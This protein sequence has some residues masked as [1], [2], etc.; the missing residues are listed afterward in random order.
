MKK[1][2]LID[3][4]K[5][6][7]LCFCLP[8]IIGFL[9]FFIKPVSLSIRYAFSSLNFTPD[10]LVISFVGLKNFK[11]ALFVDPTYI[12]TIVTSARDMVIRVPIVLL[13]SLFIAVVLSHKFKG[14]L[15][16]RAVFFLPV[17]VVSGVILE[18]LNNDYLSNQIISGEAASG[19]FATGNSYSILMSLGF[20]KELIE[21]M[22]PFAYSIFDL[23]WS[24]G[25][26]ILIFLAAL[27]TV[28]K[29]LYE[30]ARIEGAT[31]WEAFWKITFPSVSPMI[32]MNMIYVIADYFTTSTN[33]V[34]QMINKQTSNMRFEYASG[35]SWMYFIVVGT[36]IGIVFF[37]VDKYVVYTVE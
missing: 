11:E 28:P 22:V 23:I 34:I 16:F 26:P 36:I 19:L 17:I 27:Q 37:I 18:I 25:V 24:A 10:G 35:L 32:L 31:S 9:L 20:S 3:K 5:R 33:P 2:S 12:R 14:R 29:Q 30:V 15:F 6:A 21:I 4:K 7:G 13:L 1:L 8:F